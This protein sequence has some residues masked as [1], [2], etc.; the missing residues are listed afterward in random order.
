MFYET[1]S[2]RKIKNL[3]SRIR[4]V[5]GGASASKTISILIWLIAY[6]QTHKSEIISVVSESLPHLKRGAMRDF[7]SIMETQGYY[8]DD[9][10]NRSDF[11]YTFETGTRLEFFSV[12]QYEK[13][14]GPRRDL[15]FINEANNVPY[16]T[17]TQLEI[18]TRKIIWLDWNPTKEFWWYTDVAPYTQHDFLILTY[19]DNE[20]L[21]KQEIEALESHKRNTAWWRV[22]GEGLLGEVEGQ[23]YTGWQ[24]IESIPFEA[25][26]VSYGL[27]FGYSNDPTACAAIYEYN[28][29]YIFDEILYQKGLSNKQIAD[30]LLSQ[31]KALVIADSADPKSIDELHQYGITITGSTKGT[32]SVNQGIQYLRSQQISMTKRSVNMIKEYRNYFWMTD[33]E[34]KII[35][36][37]SPMFNHMMDALRYGMG[38]KFIDY[39]PAGYTPVDPKRFKDRPVMSQFG[40]VGW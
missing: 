2:T 19:K 3:Y 20:A 15:L 38:S 39:K 21:S 36:E 30:F 22:Y 13:V 9:R 4:A 32:G 6:A 1:T 5:S 40:G 28:G 26:L 34:G 7:L 33:K 10:W 24:I 25:K 23:I 12:D 37:P 29:G 35:N 14:K 16:E 17:F 27:D 8:N 11:I 31:P 18:R